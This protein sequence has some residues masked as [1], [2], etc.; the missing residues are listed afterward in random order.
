LS[1]AKT[2]PA[3]ALKPDYS[4]TDRST[5]P[6]R[7]ESLPP[8][9]KPPQDLLDDEY[10]S[11]I[12]HNAPTP[13]CMNLP[14]G[15]LIR[16][17]RAWADFIGYSVEELGKVHWRQ[18]THPEDIEP[19]N[20]LVASMIE[21]KVSVGHLEKRYFRKDG[22][23]V[24]GMLK[25]NLIRD[26]EG[27]PAYFIAQ[28]I[29]ITDS[30]IAELKLEAARDELAEQAEKLTILNNQ[31]EHA[32]LAAEAANFNKSEFLAQMSHELRTPLNSI[33][34][35]NELIR[36]ELHGP[37]GAEIY[38]EY[39]DYI[40][41]SAQHLLSMINDLLDLSKI[42]AGKVEL[43]EEWNDLKSLVQ[44]VV[45]MTKGYAK[46]YQMQVRTSVDE[47]LD[48]LYGDVR[49][50]KQILVNLVT[51]AI[52]Y[53]EEGRE[54]RLSVRRSEDPAGIMV[55]IA[56]DGIGMTPEQVQQALRPFEQVESDLSRRREGTGLGLPLARELVLLHGG[57]FEIVSAPGKGTEITISFPDPAPDPAAE[58]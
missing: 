47:G 5:G 33:L 19:D 2:S 29:D 38:K 14:D 48:R 50:V 55:A 23:L 27:K 18:I 52:K 24:W 42:E 56:D 41:E 34:G 9:G 22:K 40:G 30:K 1:E 57:R 58:T 13:I 20:R 37:L 43:L 51:N 21:G 53:S 25:L 10:Y 36:D 3:K 12:F 16:A 44:S 39:S 15:T 45:T 26:E 54:V 11:V 49:A 17:N 31:L 46:E 35:F 32:K 7:V 28:I 4:P 6:G 8:P